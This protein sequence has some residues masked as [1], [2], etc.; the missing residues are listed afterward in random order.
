MRRFRGIS[1]E[2][3]IMILLGAFGDLIMINFFTLLMCIPI[4]TAGA[5]LTAGC[6]CFFKWDTSDQRALFKE[7]FKAFKQNFKQ[8][9]LA[10]LIILVGLVLGIGDLYYTIY[11]ADSISVFYL[12][13]AVILLFIFC[14]LAMW[15]FPLIARY[16]N[17]F[18]EQIKNAFYLSMGR[19]P[20]TLLMWILWGVPILLSYL[21]GPFFVLFAFLWVTAF[22]AVQ[23]WITVKTVSPVFRKLSA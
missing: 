21:F 8:A 10:W 23:I 1:T 6:T 3:R 14:S 22:L 12:I 11:V 13:F 9:T 2:N 17:S 19:L 15:V 18:G 7:F 5:S 4:V 20:R 16:E